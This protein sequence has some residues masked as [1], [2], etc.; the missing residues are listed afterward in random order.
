M[1]AKSHEPISSLPQACLLLAL[2]LLLFLTWPATAGDNQNRPGSDYANF[3]A[4]SAFVC[5][6]TCGGESKCRAFTY[7][8]PGLQGAAGRCWLKNKTP[9]AFRDPCCVSGL[10]PA[11]ING[12]MKA[13]N[14]SDRPGGDFQNFEIGGWEKCQSA[15]QAN[16]QCSSWT[17]ARRGTQGP[18][19]VCWLKSSVARPIFNEGMVSGVKFKPATVDF[20]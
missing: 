6:N 5:S 2:L 3:E 7:V 9:Q 17:Y 19:G 16:G 11:G 15:C 8:K 14:K 10:H 12:M 20:D 18:R 13:E 4:N 1:Q